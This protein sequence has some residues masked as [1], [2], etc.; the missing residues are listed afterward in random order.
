M[1]SSASTSEEPPFTLSIADLPGI[2]EGAHRNRGRGCAFLK[3][4]EHS[5]IIA[6]VVDVHGFQYAP[7]LHEPYRQ[8]QL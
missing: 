5:D 7:T 8:A 1:S 3:H 2:V 6:M 4:L